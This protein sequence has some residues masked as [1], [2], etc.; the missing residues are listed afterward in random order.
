[1]FGAVYIS[2]VYAIFKN[3]KFNHRSME[4]NNAIKICNKFAVNSS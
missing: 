2:K 3:I 4:K 1:M